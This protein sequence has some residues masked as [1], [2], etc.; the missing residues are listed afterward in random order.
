V[1]CGVGHRCGSDPVLLWFGRRPAAI[2]PTRPLAWE[3][4][5]AMGVAL[6]KAKKPKKKKERLLLIT[7][8]R[9][10]KLMILVLFYI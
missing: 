7:K 8:Y 3:A 4:P 2:A 9:Y 10:L 1:S 6:E 5:Y